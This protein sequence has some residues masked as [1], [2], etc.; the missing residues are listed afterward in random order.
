MTSQ[1]PLAPSPAAPRP[2]TRP[3]DALFS[4]EPAPLHLDPLD[5]YDAGLR[6][7]HL[8]NTA[9]PIA[10][11]RTI[12]QWRQEPSTHAPLLRSSLAHAGRMS[13]YAHVPFCQSRCS[14]C[15]YTVLDRHDEDTQSDYFAALDAEL[16][17][18]VDQLELRGMPLAGFDIGGGTPMLASPDRISDLVRRVLGIFRPEP[19]FGI[20]IETTPRIAAEHPERLRAC[21]DAG[22]DRISMGLQM[23]NAHLLRAYGR[24]GDDDLNAQAASAIRAAGYRRFNVDLMYGFPSQSVADLLSSL[25]AALALDPDVVTLYR[26]RYKGTRVASEASEV[27]QAQVA[28]LAEAAHDRLCSAGFAANAGKNTFSRHT[29]EA[30]TSAYLTERVINSTPY[31]GL[32]LGA[33]TFTNHLLAYQH[34][35]ASKKLD[36]YLESVR[37][38]VLPIQDLYRLPPSEG[39]AKMI[40]V[41]FYFGGI[42]LD[43]F[44]RVFL[45]PLEARFPAEVLFVL[46]RELMEYHGRTLRLTRE[47]ARVFPGVVSLFYSDAVKSH[48]L[49]L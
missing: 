31:L 43:A 17:L 21:R 37:Q 4:P 9:Y 38:G 44:E 46:G 36:R 19:G 26:M 13:L 1:A 24:D 7:H 18:A 42:D 33:Q 41:S 6:S 32:G 11:R 5:V 10:H 20:S 35:A 15:E 39:M 25:D 45:T 49:S 48:L 28:A 16:S 27:S 40:A 2:K 30:G 22:I 8:A 23:V 3:A 29:G 14:Y 12:W 47:G 34:G